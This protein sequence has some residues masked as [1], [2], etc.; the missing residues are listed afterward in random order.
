MTLRGECRTTQP[1]SYEYN[2]DYKGAASSSLLFRTFPLALDIG[3]GKSHIAE[4]LNKVQSADL[5]C[6][7]A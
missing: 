3:C 6:L 2:L 5:L 1:D 4:H 7:R